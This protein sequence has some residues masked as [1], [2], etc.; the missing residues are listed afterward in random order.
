MSNFNL[1]PPRNYFEEGVMDFNRGC[2]MHPDFR[3]EFKRE[4]EEVLSTPVD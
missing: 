1:Y 2:N 4:A 3:S